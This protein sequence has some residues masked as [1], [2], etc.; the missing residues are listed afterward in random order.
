MRTGAFA[1]FFVTAVTAARLAAADEDTTAADVAGA[2]ALGQEGVKLAD[3]GNCRD[4]IDRLSRAE[5]IFHAP[6]TLERLGECQVQV[7]KIVTGTENL[8]KVVRESLPPN[9]PAAFVQAQERAKRILADA[10]PKIAKLRIVVTGPAEGSATVKVDGEPVPPAMLTSNRPTDPGEHT[11][12]ASAPGYKSA[13]STITLGEG[14]ADSVALV[15]EVD[16]NARKPEATPAAVPPAPAPADGHPAAA[17]SSAPPPPSSPNR[18][19]AYIAF[20]VGGAGVV[21]GTIFGA[22]ALGKKGS[23]NDACAQK[24]CTPDRQNDIDTGKT[25][26]TV[27]TVGFVVGAVGVVAGA[28]LFFTAG[29]GDGASSAARRLGPFAG[30]DARG[31]VF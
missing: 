16:P 27:S 15:L 20:G 29:S 17:A 30:V 19:P 26:G 22:L 3:S 1:L 6:T 5:R 25:F 7:G 23:L 31:L 12:E 9:A 8:N 2:R 13:T 24:I 21:V 14:G 11:V 4:A 28:V 10:R 18:L